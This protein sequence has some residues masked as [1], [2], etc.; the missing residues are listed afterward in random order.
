MRK[1]VALP[2]KKESKG[3]LAGGEAPKKLK[4]PSS[5]KKH[6][7]KTTA[8]NAKVTPVRPKYAQDVGQV[9]KNKAQKSSP[10]STDSSSVTLRSKHS[11]RQAKKDLPLS[12]K[13]T[14]EKKLHK[15]TT[16]STPH[17]VDPHTSQVL[18]SVKKIHVQEHLK[19]SSATSSLPQQE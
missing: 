18:D 6:A 11:K 4:E 19:G 5:G 16:S 10:P 9:V 3:T 1:L 14:R 17:L 15:P 12:A 7:K 13:P 2:Q 8:K